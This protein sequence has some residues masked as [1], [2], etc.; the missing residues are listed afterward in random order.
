MKKINFIS[1]LF[2]LL[3]MCL[4]AAAQNSING[5]IIDSKDSLPLIGV[6]VYIPD[7]KLGALTKEDGTYEINNIPEGIYLVEVEYNS[8]ASQL[9]EAEVDGA[10]TLNFTLELSGIEMP[11]LVV[12]G[13]SSATERKTDPVP[14]NVVTQLDLLQNSSANI[15]NALA[16]SPGVSEMTVGPSISKPVIRGLGYNRVVTMNDGVRQEGQQWF[17]EFGE[18]IDEYSIY[19]A[20]ILRGPAS[21]SYGSDAMAGVINLLSFPTPAEGEI[22]GSVLSNYQ[23]NNGLFGESID[24]GGNKKD[25]VWDMRYS[26]KMAH[27]YQNKYD[28][29]VLNSG[30][31][32]SDF[33][34]M[35]GINRNWGYSHLTVSSF[36]QH[37]GIIEGA[38]DSATGKFLE[39]FL[40]AGPNDS[41]GIAQENIFKKYNDFPVIHQHIRHYKVVL[42]N[43]FALGEG[44]LN[45]RIGFQQNHRQEANDL[46]QGDFYNNYFFMNTINYDVRY[47]MPE[48]NHFEV[49]YG[50]NGMQQ[51]SQDKGTAFVLPEYSLFDA[52]GF[53]IAK[54][55]M[56]RLSLS[57]GLRYDVRMLKGKDLYVDST[58]KRV[59]SSQAGAIS[60][61]T[62]YTSSFSG[63]SGSF[64]MTYDFTE[65]F[66]GKIN[67]S[68]GYRAPG[69][70]ESGANGIHDGTPFYEIG[71]HNLKAESSLEADAT[72]GL[73][74]KNITLEATAF[75]N[76]INNYIFAE[77]LQ[78]VF[79]GDSI[80]TDPALP[81]DVGVGPAFKFVQ[82]NAVLSGGEGILNIHPSFAHWLQ[83]ENSFSLVNAIQ[84][85]QPDSTKYLPYTPPYK[86]RSEIKLVCTKG[87]GI[88]KNS[89]FK[90][91]VDHYA[92]QDKI[93]YKFNNET[94]TPAYTLVNA[95]VGTDICPK[96]GTLCSIYISANNL[97]DVAYQSSMSRLKYTD[98]NYVTGRI[99]VYNM[100]RNFSFKLVIP[101]SVIK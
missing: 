30:F 39:H 2:I 7:L 1:L 74:N 68:R 49:S 94:V 51:N 59:A 77:K 13:V 34:F 85:N 18:E 95:G 21:L 66:Y 58:G 11:Q 81:A 87:C 73:N 47:V 101:V 19:K 67:I 52:G 40:A 72:L 36:D 99:G 63:W 86:F 42:D 89:Y 56:D 3:L 32:E 65:S 24:L 84:K 83:F 12:T 50:V 29:Y 20:E 26:N 33:K 90:F 53:V 28:G 70:Q 54:K 6:S 15:I 8:Y 93:Y 61:F 69:A 38:R 10:L 88:F 44:K 27:C 80:R 9:K 17:D 97:T 100:G 57:G 78:S 5:K 46:S 23:T 71:D 43:S 55:A 41:M 75:V 64:G 62:A 14:V 76:E 25:L 37:L 79:D 4:S 96:K 48:K 91:G 31:S 92:E 82:G 22:R 60:E 16:N 45:V 98:E 35:T